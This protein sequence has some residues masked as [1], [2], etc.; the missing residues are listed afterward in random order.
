MWVKHKIQIGPDTEITSQL[1]EDLIADENWVGLGMAITK[2]FSKLDQI[3]AELEWEQL[4]ALGRAKAIKEGQMAPASKKESKLIDCR[5][6]ARNIAT[7][8]GPNRIC[9]RCGKKL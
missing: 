4:G 1:V 7:P 2:L 3:K 8:P 5:C 9:G 6:G